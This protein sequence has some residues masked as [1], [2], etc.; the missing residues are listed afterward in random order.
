MIIDAHIH[1]PFAEY[2]EMK[3]ICEVIRLAKKFGVSKLF[4]LGDVFRH[5][6]FQ[7][8]EQIK[9]INDLTI[10][11]VK[12]HPDSLVGFCYLNPANSPDFMIEEIERCVVKNGFKGLKFEISLNCRSK[13]L[14]VVMQKA[15]ELGCAVIQHS[16]YRPAGRYN[17]E[18]TPADIADLAS[19]F[20]DVKIIMPHLAGCGMRGILDIAGHKNVYVDS[21]G[22]LAVAGM[23]EYAVKTLGADRIIYGSDIPGRDFSAQIGR[24]YGA[25]ISKKDKIK[26]LG[27]NAVKIFN[28]K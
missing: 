12:K 24:I 2:K 27:L 25:E 1:Y 10:E 20:P 16:W 7:N 13:K 14:D 3:D 19:R 28:L 9:E 5:G 6:H 21:S 4:L 15:G 26:I 11:L 8:E 23:V 18:S 17:E 22:S